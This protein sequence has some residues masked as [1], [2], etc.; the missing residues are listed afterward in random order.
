MI[1]LAWNVKH[2]DSLRQ[3]ENFYRDAKKVK[4]IKR[5]TAGK[6]ER[7]A[8]GNITKA[9]IF[10]SRDIPNARIEPN[11]KWFTNSRVISQQSLSNF[12]EA[13]AQQSSDPYS[14]LLKTNKLPMSLI[15]DDETKKVHGPGCPLPRDPWR[16]S[17]NCSI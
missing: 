9:A 3:G 17:T 5:L 4:T 10:Q 7:D 6:A 16:V 8:K 15:R 14:F 2:A 13:V 1:V 12:R 11:R